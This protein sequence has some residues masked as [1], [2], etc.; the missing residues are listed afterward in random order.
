MRRVGEVLAACDG[1]A[2]LVEVFVGRGAV[3]VVVA[4]R[5]RVLGVQPEGLRVR[6]GDGVER[7]ALPLVLQEEL[8]A[9]DEQ[10]NDEG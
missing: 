4:A 8:Q 6:V 9:N 1:G 10:A 2:L 5:A 7:D 3:V